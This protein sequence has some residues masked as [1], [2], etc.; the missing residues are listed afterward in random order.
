MKSIDLTPTW[1]FAV[2]IYIEGLQNPEATAEAT[3][4]AKEELLR[5]ARNFEAAKAHVGKLQ[6]A[7][8]EATNPQPKENR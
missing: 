4:G 5:R 1:E 3:K 2:S 6:E 7:L 8:D